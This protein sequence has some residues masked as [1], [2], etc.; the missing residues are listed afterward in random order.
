MRT[1]R[2]ALVIARRDYVATVWSRTFL[3]FLIGPLLPLIFGV[4]GPPRGRRDPRQLSRHGRGQAAGALLLQAM[5]QQAAEEIG[6]DGWNRAN[7]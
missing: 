7:A 3:I 1:L 5:S 2:S 4:V 6:R